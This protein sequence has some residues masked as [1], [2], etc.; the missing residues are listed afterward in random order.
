M[1]EILTTFGKEIVTLIVWLIFAALGF[2][3]KKIANRVIDTK[4]KRELAEDVVTFIEQKYKDLHGADK[5]N[6]A[7]E[8]FTQIL[9]ERGISTSTAEVQTLIE[10]AV[11]AF[12]DI[13][14]K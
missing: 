11:G 5:F 9:T 7:V 13:F 8:Y 1:T 2:A 10:S 12:N 4:E 14:N 3:A 6:K